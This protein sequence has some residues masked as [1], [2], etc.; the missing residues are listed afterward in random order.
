M[1]RHRTARRWAQTISNAL[2]RYMRQN[3]IENLKAP[4]AGGLLEQWG[5]LVDSR[6]RPGK[7]LRDLLRAGIITG[8]EQPG[9]PNSTWFIRRVE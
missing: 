7:P 1:K 3:G 4:E 5:L 8:Q 6:Q 9:G 2:Q